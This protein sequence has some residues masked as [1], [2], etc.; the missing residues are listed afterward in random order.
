MMEDKQELDNRILIL[1]IVGF[2]FPPM[3]VVAFCMSRSKDDK[4]SKLLGRVGCGL[5]I[6]QV[7][8]SICVLVITLSIV[9]PLAIASS[10]TTTVG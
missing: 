2:L 7:A 4:S 6:A 9:I 10:N 8:I 1:F 3:W 5:C